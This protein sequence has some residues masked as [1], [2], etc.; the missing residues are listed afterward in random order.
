[1][2]KQK[3]N[4]IVSIFGEIEEIVARQMIIEGNAWLFAPTAAVSLDDIPEST[5]TNQRG[6]KVRL[7]IAL[8]PQR[9]KELERRIEDM[10]Q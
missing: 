7:V 4:Q 2:K 3:R 6:E 8:P 1:M 9:L 5:Q 10:R